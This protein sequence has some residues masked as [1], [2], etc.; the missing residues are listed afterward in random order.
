M[1]KLVREKGESVSV[2]YPPELLEWV[3]GQARKEGRTRSEFLV[4]VA[5]RERA[6]S[7]AEAERIRAILAKL[8]PED[9][10]HLLALLPPDLKPE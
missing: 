3:D 9:Q 4:R 7:L 10:A 1:P 8:P 2:R 6:R 5:E